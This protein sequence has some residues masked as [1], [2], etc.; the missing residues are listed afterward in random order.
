MRVEALDEASSDGSSGLPDA[1]EEHLIDTQQVELLGSGQLAPID[2]IQRLEDR[3][4]K[5][6]A[7]TGSPGL[8]GWWNGSWP[9]ARTRASK[10][11][12]ALGRVSFLQGALLPGP[13]DPDARWRRGRRSG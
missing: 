9:V 1:V 10:A 11:C 13:W 5:V 8:R 7:G 3:A 4:R 2:A 12:D 6:G